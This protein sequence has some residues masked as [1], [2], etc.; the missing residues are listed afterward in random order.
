MTH[1]H[2][3][4][5]VASSERIAGTYPLA[6]TYH[7]AALESEMVEI[8]TRVSDFVPE[9]TGLELPGEPPAPL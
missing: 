5:R 3:N 1:L 7:T 6:E 9:A 8:T 2:A 4:V